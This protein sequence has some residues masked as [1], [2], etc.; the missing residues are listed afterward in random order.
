MIK[1]GVFLQEIN[2]LFPEP[3]PPEPKAV[4][5]WSPFK[6]W[7]HFEMAEFVYCHTRMFATN[8]D[9]L[10]T[11]LAGSQDGNF[12]FKDHNDLCNVIDASDLGDVLWQHSSFRYDKELP[13]SQVPGWMT[14]LSIIYVSPPALGRRD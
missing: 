13:E 12:L 10:M 5:D 7:A 9:Q 2:R 4:D 6:S 3:L 1:R 8:I 11:M 14:K